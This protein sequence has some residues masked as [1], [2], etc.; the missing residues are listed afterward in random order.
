MITNDIALM[1]TVACWVHQHRS[2]MRYTSTYPA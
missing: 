1:F 2:I